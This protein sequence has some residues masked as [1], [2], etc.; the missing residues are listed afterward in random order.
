MLHMRVEKR[1]PTKAINFVLFILL[2]CQNLL[3]RT[4]VKVKLGLVAHR[5][6]LLLNKPK[7]MPQITDGGDGQR[8]AARLAVVVVGKEHLLLGVERNRVDVAVADAAKLDGAVDLV[9]EIF[10]RLVGL[11]GN[12]DLLLE[13]VG[14]ALLAHQMHLDIKNMHGG[15]IFIHLLGLLGLLGNNCRLLDR[16]CDVLGNN[17]RLLE[18]HRDVLGNNCCHAVAQA[19]HRSGD[20]RGCKNRWHAVGRPGKRNWQK[21]K[22]AVLKGRN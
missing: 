9:D 2:H 14:L 5:H 7:S 13:N 15:N 10:G 19:L 11:A 4:E 1:T 21:N 22:F 20:G 12:G 18:G 8:R 6:A 17:F 3:E 16:H